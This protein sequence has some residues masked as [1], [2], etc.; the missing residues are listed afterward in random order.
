MKKLFIL[1]LGTATLSLSFVRPAQAFES[2][3]RSLAWE[4]ISQSGEIAYNAAGYPYGIHY[5]QPGDTVEMSIAVRNRSRNRQA[6]MWYGKSAL[7]SEG[8]SYPNAHAI[9]VG[10]WDPMDNIPHFSIPPVLLSTAIAWLITTA[11]RSIK[12]KP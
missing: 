8:P 3:P 11:L 5:V 9:G 10:T 2:F 12:A 7:L 1:L 4:L 6:E